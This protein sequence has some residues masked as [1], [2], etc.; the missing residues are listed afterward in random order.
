MV[1]YYKICYTAQYPDG[2]L[3]DPSKPYLEANILASTKKEAISN[4]MLEFPGLKINVIEDPVHM[5][6]KDYI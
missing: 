5:Q 3:L 1:D 4:L 2:K 6:M